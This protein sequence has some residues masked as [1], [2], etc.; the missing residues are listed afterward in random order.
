RR[1]KCPPPG[2]SANTPAYELGDALL[3]VS[4]ALAPNGFPST[5]VAV[6][7]IVFRP[8]T[9]GLMPFKAKMP[10]LAG[11]KLTAFGAAELSAPGLP[12]ARMPASMATPP[13]KVL[14][15]PR[16]QRPEPVFE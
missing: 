14:L 10:V 1:F 13:V 8:L 7:L 2:P 15:P 12:S 9:T 6:G 5:T 3:T 11:P 4:V 16:S